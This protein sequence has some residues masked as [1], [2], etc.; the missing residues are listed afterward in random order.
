MSREDGLNT[1]LQIKSLNELLPTPSSKLAGVRRPAEFVA[2]NA[3][4]PHKLSWRDEPQTQQDQAHSWHCTQICLGS[5]K[6]KQTTR[7]QTKV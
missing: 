2:V 3:V 4:R 6:E 7:S 5:G 1:F